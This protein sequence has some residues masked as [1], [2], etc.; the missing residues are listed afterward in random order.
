M[1]SSQQDG[2]YLFI[3]SKNVV[4]AGEEM[5]E[6]IFAH[7]GVLDFVEAGVGEMFIVEFTDE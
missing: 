3:I 7:F 2:D 1:F 6:I 5:T 4:H